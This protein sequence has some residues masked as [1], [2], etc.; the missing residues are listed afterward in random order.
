MFL[1]LFSPR[2]MMNDTAHTQYLNAIHDLLV[3]VFDLEEL[4][5][6]CFR[7]S[8]S[9]DDIPGSGRRGKARELVLLL[10]RTDRLA[11]LRDAVTALRPKVAWPEIP[12]TNQSQSPP[13]TGE[14]TRPTASEPDTSP[15]ARPRVSVTAGEMKVEKLVQG[16]YQE[17]GEP[18]D[19]LAL[20]PHLP[21]AAIEADSLA[22]GQM[23]QGVR[24]QAGPALPLPPKALV[25]ALRTQVDGLGLPVTD[26]QEL[27]AALQAVAAEPGKAAP[28]Q[29]R[30]L[31]WLDEA[32][33]LVESVAATP[34]G[35]AFLVQLLV[36]RQAV[37]NS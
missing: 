23:T 36:L 20:L 31:A 10:D 26:R 6:L 8:L 34:S 16:V 24:I 19:W 3:R 35:N 15:P 5:D 32:A 30:M 21:D 11:E 9:L 12:I 22:A 13:D 1:C 25:A 7:L 2:N 4:S 28:N 37:L 27:D 18:V 33:A 29:R 14:A 17:G